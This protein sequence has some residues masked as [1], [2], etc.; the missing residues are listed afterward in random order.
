MISATVRSG[1]PYPMPARDLANE[2]RIVLRH[3]AADVLQ[4]HAAVDV[5]SVQDLLSRELGRAREL[6]GEPPVA[7]DATVTLGLLPGD[8]R[9]VDVLLAAQREQ[10]VADVRRRQKT[11]AL[12]LELSSPAAVL[13]RWF[14]T[15]GTGWTKA[16]QEKASEAAEAFASYRPPGEQPVEHALV[17]AV[18]EFF[19]SFPDPAQKQMLYGLLVASMR[20]A[21]RP[22]HAARVSALAEAALV[23]TEPPE[24]EHDQGQGLRDGVDR[25]RPV[26]ATGW[27]WFLA[28]RT[29][30]LAWRL[31]RRTGDDFDATWRRSRVQLRPDE[32]GYRAAGHHLDTPSA[33]Q[34]PAKPPSAL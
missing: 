4:R 14:E 6:V 9:A 27:R 19:G 13:A 28:P 26:S 21:E 34:A 22:V 1:P 12:A 24:A 7:F 15:D 25:A 2:I 33:D 31:S 29:S 32:M 20:A 8:A 17:E 11:S 10:T 16:A 3:A 23:H 30:W 5:A 18:R